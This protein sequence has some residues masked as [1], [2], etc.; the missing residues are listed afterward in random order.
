[1]RTTTNIRYIEEPQHVREV[2]L[3]GTTDLE[4]WTDY[5][6][7]EG[8]APVRWG[9]GR[10]VVIVAA[11]MVYLGLRLT[12]VSFSVRAVLTQS[13]GSEGCACFMPSL[14]VA[15]SPGVSGRYSRRP[16]GMAKATFQST[17]HLRCGW[18]FWAV[19]Q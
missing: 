18:M 1:M 6:K 8:L 4:F 13:T 19:R 7:A 10:Q 5:L 3:T 2:T 12:E 9:D 11:E 17:V 16:T 15:S 14:P